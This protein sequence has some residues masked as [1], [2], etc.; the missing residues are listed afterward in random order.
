MYFGYGI[1]CFVGLDVACTTPLIGCVN[2]VELGVCIVFIMCVD[3]C[4]VYFVLELTLGF[5]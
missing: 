2:N 4:C 5:A 1:A 3:A